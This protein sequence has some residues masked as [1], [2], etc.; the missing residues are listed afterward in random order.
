MACQGYQTLVCSIDTSIGPDSTD[1]ST[2][3]DSPAKLSTKYY[4]LPEVTKFMAT[5]ITKKET[6]QQDCAHTWQ[7]VF[8]KDVPA[9]AKL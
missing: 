1:T 7:C 3:P 4:Q 8:G 5:E 9:G 6:Y 2:K